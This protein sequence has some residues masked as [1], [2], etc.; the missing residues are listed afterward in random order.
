MIF[1]I[2][3]PEEKGKTTFVFEDIYWVEMSLNF[4]IVADETI[5]NSMQLEENNEYLTN[6]YSKWKG[7]MSNLK[8]NTYIIELN[9]TGGK[10]KIIA[11]TFGVDMI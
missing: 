8:L 3:W 2:E 7:T 6:S 5:L 10:I 11:K 9:S 1:E 4:G